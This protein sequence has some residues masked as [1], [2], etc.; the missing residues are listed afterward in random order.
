[1]TQNRQ[2]TYDWY[3][4][5]ASLEAPRAAAQVQVLPGVPDLIRN[6]GWWMSGLALSFLWMLESWTSASPG[7]QG[8]GD[9]AEGVWSLLLS[10]GICYGI[11]SFS[12]D[13][14]RPL[15]HL[16]CVVSAVVLLLNHANLR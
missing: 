14:S 6:F 7:H 16:L 8:F 13:H 2:E 15:A 4:E 10:L 1:M 11:Y 9:V 3:E 5:A 12:K